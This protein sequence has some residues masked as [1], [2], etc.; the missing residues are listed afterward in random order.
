MQTIEIEV[1]Y[2]TRWQQELISLVVDAGSTIEH[3]IKA[4]GVL[5]EHKELVLDDLAVGV[6]GQRKALGDVLEYGDRVE[7]YRPL[8]A[9][10]KEKRRQ[11]AAR[12]KAED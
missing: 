6:F 11:M 2:A 5:Q 3:A 1:V 7:I 9:D 4:S 8:L 12:Q 10:P